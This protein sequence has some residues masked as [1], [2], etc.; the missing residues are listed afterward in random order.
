MTVQSLL[1]HPYFLNI[2]NADISTV[3]DQYEEMLER[4]HNGE[5]KIHFD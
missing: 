2:N 1:D 3:I 4:Q 5:R